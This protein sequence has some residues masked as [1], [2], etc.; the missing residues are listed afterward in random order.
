MRHQKGSGTRKMLTPRTLWHQKSADTKKALQS[1][2]ASKVEEAAS[3]EEEEVNELPTLAELLESAE[4]TGEY[5]G[6]DP[7][8]VR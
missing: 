8:T 5:A 4:G 3:A 7:A 1:P 2:G 6:E